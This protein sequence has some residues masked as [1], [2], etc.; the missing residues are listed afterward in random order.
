MYGIGISLQVHGCVKNSGLCVSRVRRLVLSID[1]K[2]GGVFA[3]IIIRRISNIKKQVSAFTS[4]IQWP[5]L[6]LMSS[7]ADLLCLFPMVIR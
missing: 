4:W 7:S 1:A 5:F 2:V 6:L 3:Y